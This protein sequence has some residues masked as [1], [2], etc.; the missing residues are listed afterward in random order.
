MRKPAEEVDK[1]GRPQP[2]TDTGEHQS[3][4]TTGPGRPDGWPGPALWC[5]QMP[6][7]GVAIAAAVGLPAIAGTLINIGL[8][9]AI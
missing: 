3:C 8:A 9:G 6:I 1:G 7:I 4:P 5:A 2:T